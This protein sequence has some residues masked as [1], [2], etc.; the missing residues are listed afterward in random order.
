M[1]IHRDEQHSSSLETRHERG[2][3]GAEFIARLFKKP[4]NVI[5]S[6]LSHGKNASDD[7]ARALRSM[8]SDAESSSIIPLP[9]ERASSPLMATGED[10]SR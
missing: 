8:P 9:G 3:T 6:V 4:R 2:S 5:L 7:D 10:P 1:D